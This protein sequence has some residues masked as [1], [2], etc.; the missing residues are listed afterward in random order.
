MQVVVPAVTTVA[1]TLSGL[2]GPPQGWDRRPC[3]RIPA[4]AMALA[5]TAAVAPVATRPGGHRPVPGRRTHGTDG[6][7]LKWALVRWIGGIGGIL[8]VVPV[9]A[10]HIAPWVLPGRRR[11]LSRRSARPKARSRRRRDGPDPLALAGSCLSDPLRTHH[12]FFICFVPLVW[13]GLRH[14]LAGTTLATLVIN[15]GGYAALQLTGAPVPVVADFLLFEVAFAAVGTGARRG[16]G[17]SRPRG[18]GAGREPG[19]PRGSPRRRPPGHVGLRPANRT[20]GL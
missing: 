18:G 10:M 5:V 16:G 15:L 20:R 11:A 6:T 4:Q 13:I 2:A 12:A 1:Y 19:A 17:S 7:F 3:P 14:G 8:T 9:V